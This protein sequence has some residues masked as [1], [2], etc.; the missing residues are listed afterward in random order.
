MTYKPCPLLKHGWQPV[1]H[2]GV[3]LDE[4]GGGGGGGG[5]GFIND[6][7]VGEKEVR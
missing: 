1:L 2:S 4:Q 5:W 6:L 7:G 3:R